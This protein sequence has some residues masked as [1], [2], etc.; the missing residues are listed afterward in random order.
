MYSAK[1]DVMQKH[2]PTKIQL[3]KQK[4]TYMHFNTLPSLGHL[5]TYPTVN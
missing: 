5:D 3:L 1:A 2:V 4:F